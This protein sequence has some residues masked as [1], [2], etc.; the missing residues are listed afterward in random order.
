[1]ETCNMDGSTWHILKREENKNWPIA[2]TVSASGYYMYEPDWEYQTPLLYTLYY[3]LYCHCNCID[4][5]FNFQNIFFVLVWI[6]GQG[7][8]GKSGMEFRE[9]L[10]F[11]KSRALTLYVDKQSYFLVSNSCGLEVF[12]W[13]YTMDDCS[14]KCVQSADWAIR[15]ISDPT[16]MPN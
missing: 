10:S 4:K 8:N 15:M 6:L 16:I 9:C 12:F 7:I 11:C 3:C 5:P 13:K 1:M 2:D 14:L